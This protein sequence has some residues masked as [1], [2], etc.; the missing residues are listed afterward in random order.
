MKLVFFDLETTGLNKD[1]EV[2]EIGAI[3][4][5][6]AEIVG[7]FSTLVKPSKPLPRFIT[8]LTGITQEDVNGAQDSNYIKKTFKSFIEDAILVAHNASFDKSFLEKFLGEPVQNSVIDTLELARLTF[9]EFP[10]HSLESL[11]S[12]LNIKKEKS[13]RA[14]NDA[15]MLYELFK[16]ISL[17]LK[18]FSP[19]QISVIRDIISD[20]R[21][22]NF[23]FETE[24]RSSTKEQIEP[25][26]YTKNEIR[27]LPFVERV[28]SVDEGVFY[29]ENDDFC[30]VADDIKK[31]RKSLVVFYSDE[32]EDEL[33]NNLGTLKIYNAT[34]I[35]S[36]VCLDRLYF[37]L[38]YPELLPIELK[39]DFAILASYIMKT[40]DFLLEK[41]PTH[42]LK[43]KALKDISFC[44]NENC[45]HK[46]HC[47][48]LEKFSEIENSDVIF[49][50]QASF[51]NSFFLLNT[52]KFDALFLLEAYRFPKVFF[53]QKLMLS[54]N[55][56]KMILAGEDE[57]FKNDLLTLFDHSSDSDDLFKMKNTFSENVMKVKK[58][59]S[60]FRDF[61]FST[62]DNIL[63]ISFSNPQSF[64]EEVKNSFNSIF[65]VSPS[66][67]FGRK[68]IL[69]DFTNLDGE[70]LTIEEP[71]YK[72]LHIIPLFMH[73]PNAKEFNDELLDLFEK[74]DGIEPMLFLFEGRMQLNYV[75]AEINKLLGETNNN[76]GNVV[77]SGYELPMD[78]KYKLIFVVKLPFNTPNLDEDY[79]FLYLKNFI[80]DHVISKDKSVVLYFDGRLKDGE[81][82]FK[83]EDAFNTK[84]FPMERK[85]N[86]LKLI[87]D[88]FSI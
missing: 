35:E 49:I 9:P 26:P 66:I 76:E 58:E 14:F 48:L 70:E 15:M 17:E 69:K 20:S 34:N 77:F 82:T 53:S 11:V 27:T 22:F 78:K 60:S 31:C 4:V 12:T 83:I 50:K 10:S 47:P 67:Y 23:L 86:F 43:S 41:A 87:R 75:K 45:T 84:V 59:H 74:L 29:V 13:H 46:N 85:D 73:S 54:K 18:T 52:F 37:Y 57:P 32:V 51:L 72:I 39:V 25:L 55:D 21:A 63:S 38:R 88:H 61:S 7:T 1:D 71:S 3:K 30:R 28:N 40:G 2:I 24:N 42:I 6:D 80:F 44:T 79:A 64:F 5:V 62:E 16:K 81:Y 56:F 19:K 68:N 33:K 8:N 36:F 65:F